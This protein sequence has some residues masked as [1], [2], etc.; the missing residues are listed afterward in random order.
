MELLSISS[1][2]SMSA[3]N[4]VD[5]AVE[6]H[7]L[8]DAR[9]RSAETMVGPIIVFTLIVRAAGQPVFRA[10]QDRLRSYRRPGMR[11]RPCSK[12]GFSHPIPDRPAE[13]AFS[14]T[15][16][17]FESPSITR[18]ALI[19]EPLKIGPA[20]AM[21]MTCASRDLPSLSMFGVFFVPGV[22][23]V[24]AQRLADGFARCGGSS[25]SSKLRSAIALRRLGQA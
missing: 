2:V 6:I 4:A 1:L 24:V 7:E 16:S 3:R 13:Y 5:V 11:C 25:L 18:R 19:F 17:V 20:S 9:M 22:G 8:H 14:P 21:S 12:C 15:A 10:A 23:R